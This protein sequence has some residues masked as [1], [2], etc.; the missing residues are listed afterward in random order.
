[1]LT[2]CANGW[3]P[4]PGPV[5]S[6]SRQTRSS[7]GSC[8]ST[9]TCDTDR[10]REQ[11]AARRRR[12]PIGRAARQIVLGWALD[13]ERDDRIQEIGLIGDADRL[14]PVKAGYASQ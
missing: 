5:R 4:P 10:L 13:V 9:K 7:R 2:G 6:G 12:R 3:A 1:M 8:G 14:R 11:T